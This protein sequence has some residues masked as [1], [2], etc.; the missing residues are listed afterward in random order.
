MKKF[1]YP[2]IFQKEEDGGYSVYFADID[3]AVTCGDNLEDAVYMAEDCL[4]IWIY[5]YKQ[6]KKTL[7]K[8]SDIKAIKCGANQFVS[9]VALDYADYIRRTETKPVRKTLYIPRNL[10]DQAESIGINFSQVLRTALE[11][12]LANTNRSP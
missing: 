12:Q 3:G 10:N 8:P 4:G 7:P 5:D 9:L 1:V 6:N 11:N 2:A